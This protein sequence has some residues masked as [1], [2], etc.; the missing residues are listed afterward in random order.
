MFRWFSSLPEWLRNG[1]LVLVGSVGGWLGSQWMDY[2][3]AY[4]E[5]LGENY[6]RF[7]TAASAVQESLIRFA[8]IAS[9]ETKKS[10]EDVNTIQN[11]LIAA[12]SAAEDL[13][14]RLKADER[15]IAGYRLATVEL[16]HESDK[17]TGPLDAKPLVRAVN[18]YLVAE[19]SLRDHVVEQQNSFLY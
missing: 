13:Q 17:V 9:G 18:S 7:D 4:K 3:T 19:K 6:E 14:R 8:D 11:R 10:D 1:I 15:V 12:V 2:R 5:S 16:K